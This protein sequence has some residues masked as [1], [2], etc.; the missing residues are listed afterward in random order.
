MPPGRERYGPITSADDREAWS[1]GAPREEAKSLLQFA[2]KSGEGLAG[3][4]AL[5]GLDQREARELL[6]FVRERPDVTSGVERALNFR[7]R[8]VDELESLTSAQNRSGGLFFR[9]QR[10]ARD[11]TCQRG[12]TRLM[13]KLR[14]SEGH[15]RVKTAESTSLRLDHDL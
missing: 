13:T 15:A 9:L 8:V 12:S 2:A 14:V 7:I 5:V 6:D 4:L 1:S 3:L 10:S 11:S